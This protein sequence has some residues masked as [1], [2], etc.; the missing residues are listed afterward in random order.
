MSLASQKNNYSLHILLVLKQVIGS[1]RFKKRGQFKGV[2]T[3]PS[4]ET[5]G[6]REETKIGRAVGRKKG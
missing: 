3:G 4:L 2:N 5:Q 6:H 1:A